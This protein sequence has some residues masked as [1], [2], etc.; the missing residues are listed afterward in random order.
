MSSKFTRS[1]L[2][3][4]FILAGVWAGGIA[5]FLALDTR[6]GVLRTADI[7][8]IMSTG[9]EVSNSLDA[10]RR[11][12][13]FRQDEAEEKRTDPVD[14]GG[15]PDL[16]GEEFNFP[17]PVTPD[18]PAAEPAAP[19]VD[20]PVPGPLDSITGAL[21]SVQRLLQGEGDFKDIISLA[22]TA[23]ALFGGA[24]FGSSDMLFKFVLGLF[25]KKANYNEILEGKLGSRRAR[26]RARRAR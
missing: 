24:Q 14:E 13:L 15:A 4:C 10:A 25:S 18:A 21:E 19:V 6:H 17:A 23:F 2:F 26:R 16:G 7:Q 5:S 9:E 3:G 8:G 12:F 1:V 22:V 20:T 11:R